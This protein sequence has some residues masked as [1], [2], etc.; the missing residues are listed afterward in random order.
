MKIAILGTGDVGRALGKGFIESGHEVRMGSRDAKH[1]KMLGWV[2]EMGPKASGGTFA[3]AAQFGE[4]IVVA[5]LG[6]ANEAALKMAGPENFR[7]KVVIDTTNP[8]DF[9]KGMPPTLAISGSDSGG[10]RV[11]KMLPGAKV[12]KAFNIVGNSNMVHP[13]I[14]G[15][16]PD[17]LIA[18]NDAGAK[19][20]VTKLLKEWDWNVTDIGGIEGARYLEAMCIAWVLY[21]AAN[22]T[23]THAFKF[24][25]A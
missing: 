13:K 9:S 19:L 22:Q 10:E 18:G 12:V 14:A 5:T 7:G 1:E 3:E 4:M 2:K 11:Q 25:R 21:G 23:W 15:G 8:L 20:E 24:I 6:M 16:P 17:M